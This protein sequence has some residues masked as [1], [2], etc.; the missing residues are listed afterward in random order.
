MADGGV[1]GNHFSGN[2]TVLACEDLLR[3][4]YEVAAQVLRAQPMDLDHDAEKVFV[5]HRPDLSVGFA[6]LSVGY[7]FPD[8]NAIWWTAPSAS[9]ATSRRAS[10][11]S[12]RRPA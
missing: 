9:G 4:A 10:A 7:A 1:Q 5:R 2:A 12:T 8:G 3:E 6:Q 11:I